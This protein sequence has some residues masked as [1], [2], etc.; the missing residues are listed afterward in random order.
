MF[1]MTI[2]Q[3]QSSHYMANMTW[4]PPHDNQHGMTI[5]TWH[6]NHHM[7]INMTWQSSHENHHMTWQSSHG[8]INMTWQSSHRNPIIRLIK[9][10]HNWN[11]MILLLVCAWWLWENSCVSAPANGDPEVTQ[12]WPSGDPVV[13]KRWPSGDP[14]V[15]QWIKQ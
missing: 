10:Q 13:T 15:T 5:M 11:N 14:M 12:R 6:D 9:T 3:W 1:D 4:Q 2:I 7:T 8:I